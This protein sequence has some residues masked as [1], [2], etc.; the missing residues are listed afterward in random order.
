MLT[1]RTLRGLSSKLGDERRDARGPR[2]GMQ[3]WG[4][5]CIHSA[6]ALESSGG[7]W[8]QLKDIWMRWNAISLNKEPYQSHPTCAVLLVHTCAMCSNRNCYWQ[9]FHCDS[10]MRSW[11]EGAFCA[12]F[13]LCCKHKAFVMSV[14]LWMDAVKFISKEG[15]GLEMKRLVKRWCRLIL[16]MINQWDC[17]LNT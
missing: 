7:G 12:S 13:Q 3:L 2:W 10:L 5:V 16:N 9:I 15:W 14:F 1:L 6:C 8:A 11:T 4:D 17:H